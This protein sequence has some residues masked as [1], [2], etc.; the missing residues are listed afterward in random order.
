MAT[1]SSVDGLNG[2]VKAYIRR[3]L[4][5][6]GSGMKA[7][8]LDATT[9]RNAAAQAALWPRNL[10]VLFAG[11]PA[12]GG[13]RLHGF[14]GAHVV[15]LTRDLILRAPSAARWV[16]SVRCTRSR[17]FFKKRRALRP[18]C[19]L[20]SPA[21]AVRYENALFTRVMWP[22]AL[23]QVFLVERLD[24]PAGEPMKHIK[25]RLRM[26]PRCCFTRC[27]GRLLA[28]NAHTLTRNV[29]PPA[30][31]VFPEANGRERRRSAPP[32]AQTKVRRIPRL[33]VWQRAVSPHCRAD[34]APLAS[35]HQYREGELPA[36]AC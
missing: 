17:R 14:A 33:Y 2:A 5:E 19:A 35:L 21:F 1:P 13:R 36:G 26:P 6:C 31:S 25:A 32:P 29:L 20:H 7:L 10:P 24:A 23:R 30:G 28:F 11:A 18:L 22:N 8:V 3:M 27:L 34:I 12:H 15:F 16:S 4:A 9:V